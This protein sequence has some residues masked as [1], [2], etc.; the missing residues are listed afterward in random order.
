MANSVKLEIITPSKMFYRGD[1]EL[2]I[3]RTLEGDEGFMYNHSWACKL[4]DIGELWIQEAGAGQDEFRV[5]A[6]AGGFIDVK[7]SIIIYTDAAEWSEDIDMERVLSEKARAE[8]W[9]VHHEK[10][11]DPNDVIKA[12]IAI[13]KAITRSH[14]AE[15]GRRRKR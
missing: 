13:S 14:V 12:K 15:G 7:D 2:V 6:A 4:L 9:L 5:A 1:V 3:V 8:D 10:D 11:A